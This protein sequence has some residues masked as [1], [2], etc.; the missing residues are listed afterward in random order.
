MKQF[1][2]D[3]HIRVSRADLLVATGKGAAV[4]AGAAGTV[5]IVTQPANAQNAN[6]TAMTDGIN[7][8]AGIAAVAAGVGIGAMVVM[9]GFRLWR[10]TM[11]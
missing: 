1:T 5:A 10:R 8:L 7:E 11:G 4:M 9:Y 2:L 3:D 6:I